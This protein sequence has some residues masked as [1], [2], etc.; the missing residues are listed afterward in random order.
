MDV[1]LPN[2]FSTGMQTASKNTKKKDDNNAIYDKLTM[3]KYQKKAG[4]WRGQAAGEWG[5]GHGLR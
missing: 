1:L 4:R 2:T 5:V 3:D